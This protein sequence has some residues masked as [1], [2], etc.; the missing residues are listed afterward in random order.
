MTQSRTII[1]GLVGIFLV[2]VVAANTF[3]VVDQRK[4]AVVLS[5]GAPVRVVNGF[6]ENDPGLKA[7]LPFVENVIQ[8]DKRNQ[9]LEA[10][11]EEVVASDQDRLIVDAFMRFRIYDPLQFYRTLGDEHT[12]ADRLQ[13]VLN[14]SLRQVLGSA[15]SHDIIAG[16]REQLMQQ[17]RAD[18]AKQARDARLGIEVTDVRL[19]RVDLPQANEEAVFRRME[20]AREQ[21]AAQIR[22]LGEQQKREIMADADK[23]VAIT[24]GTAIGQSYQTRGDGDAKRAAIYAAAYGKDPA[25]AKFYRTLQA[26]DGALGRGDTTMVLSPQ[27]AF[28]S[29][30]EKGAGGAK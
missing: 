27:S 5:F 10:D 28:F 19:S 14:S 8:L 20:T 6:Q 3:Y 26:Y 25:F 22:S 12:A 29:E 15:T 7:K 9:P 11:Q 17:T 24:R 16:R 2:A 23:E 1:A 30:F 4:Q 18:V 13:R 21:Q